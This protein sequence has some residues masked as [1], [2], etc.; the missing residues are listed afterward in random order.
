M[1][2]GHES[3]LQNYNLF[4]HVKRNDRVHL[5]MLDGQNVVRVGKIPSTTF[6]KV[7]T[8]RD[9]MQSCMPQWMTS[10]TRPWLPPCSSPCETHSEYFGHAKYSGIFFPAY[11]LAGFPTGQWMLITCTEW[12]HYHHSKYLHQVNNILFIILLL[13]NEP[14]VVSLAPL[15]GELADLG[16]LFISQLAV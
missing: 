11:I 16:M 6:A 3:F 12:G 1:C 7:L 14:K 2:H 10:T 13:S 8:I 5:P 4:R 9:K 15:L